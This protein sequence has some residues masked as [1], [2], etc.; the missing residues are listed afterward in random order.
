MMAVEKVVQLVESMVDVKVGEKVDLKAA[1]LVAVW[2]DCLAGG[3]AE[4]T[5]RM[6]VEH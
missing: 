4:L 2:V 3:M 6:W 1:L 5:E